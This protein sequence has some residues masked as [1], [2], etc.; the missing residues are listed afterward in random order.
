MFGGN[1]TAF[2]CYR[3]PTTNSWSTFTPAQL[4][5]QSGAGGALVADTFASCIYALRGGGTSEFWKY[6]IPLNSWLRL[7]DIPA[8]VTAGGA[9]ASERRDNALFVYAI[10]GGQSSSVYRYGIHYGPQPQGIIQWYQVASLHTSGGVALQ[11]GPGACLAATNDSIF[12]IPCDPD[13][14]NATIAYS[15]VAND[16]YP[17]AY[18]SGVTPSPGCA[19]AGWY[20]VANG[21]RRLRCLVGDE[22]V[23]GGPDNHVRERWFGV[24]D[25]WRNYTST[26][27]NHQR[28]GASITWDPVGWSYAFFGNNSTAFKRSAYY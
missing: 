12:C 7:A 2:R 5:F 17:S 3:P 10:V 16:W 25:Y 19:M 20:W 9:L 8:P 23:H 21:A 11:A 28:M 24:G 22:S 26:G 18:F 15:P 14:Y 27:T 13:V 4:P 1:S 6:N